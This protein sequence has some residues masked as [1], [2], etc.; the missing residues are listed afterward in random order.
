MVELI[1]ADGPDVVCVQEVPL[2]AFSRLADWSGMQAFTSVTRAARLPLGLARRLTDLNHGLLRSALTGE[3]GAI[4]VHRRFEVDEIR[5]RVVGLQPLRR[6]AHGLRLDSQIYVVNFHINADAAELR[7]V[8]E[9]AKPEARVVLAG[10]ANVRGAWIRGYSQPLADSI[11]Q[12]LVRGLPSTPPVRW[13]DE[14]RRF[15]GRVLS[16]HAPVELTVG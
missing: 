1:T 13:S 3:G 9:V 8:T 15:E 7:R 6:A 11:D 10:D 14:R 2:W 16:D 12:I 5:R 4:L